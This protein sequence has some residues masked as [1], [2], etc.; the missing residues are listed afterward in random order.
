MDL[1][2]RDSRF[3]AA[4]LALVTAILLYF[5]PSFPKEIIA[6]FD[7]LA[8]VI[9]GVLATRGAVAGVRARR[10]RWTNLQ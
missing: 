3:W 2:L 9:I 8:A 1:L 6:A 7:A 10:I 5:V 4:L